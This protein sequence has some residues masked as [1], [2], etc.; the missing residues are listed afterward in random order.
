MDITSGESFR[1][2]VFF[3]VKETGMVET[4]TFG[5]NRNISVFSLFGEHQSGGIEITFSGMEVLQNDSTRLIGVGVEPDEA[6]SLTRQGII[7]QI[8]EALE[9]ALEVVRE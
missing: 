2:G 5:A 7:N 1:S 3:V 9:R 6:V 8:D 4:L